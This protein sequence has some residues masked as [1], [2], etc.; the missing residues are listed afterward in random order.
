MAFGSVEVGSAAVRRLTVLGAIVVLLGTVVLT[1]CGGGSDEGDK[2]LFCERLD[3][4]TNN[5]PFLA[6]GDQASAD[7]IELAFS[8]LIDRAG[9]LVEV[10]P[11]EPRGAARDYAEAAAAL[12]DL[13]AAA[14]Y[15]PTGVD[16]RAYRDQQTAYVEAAQ[17]LERYLTAEC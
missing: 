15:A 14:G 1:A 8:A 11:P 10:A 6:F 13:L 4:L 9:E 3:R 17:R 2:A 7:E 12:D 5:D 16:E